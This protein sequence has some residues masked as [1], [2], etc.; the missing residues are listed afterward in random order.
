[1]TRRILCYNMLD[2]KCEGSVQTP[3][4]AR[5]FSLLENGNILFV[6]PK[7]QGHKQVVVTDSICNII[8]EYIDFA[9][10]DL[11]N[12]T[13]YSLLQK[14][15]RGLVYS[16]PLRNEVYVF[17]KKD[18]CLLEEFLFLIDGKK[19]DDDSSYSSNLRIT[20][21]ILGDGTVLGNY[22]KGRDVFFYQK[23]LNSNRSWVRDVLKGENNYSDLLLPLCT[24]GD[25]LILSYLQEEVYQK[26]D[27]T[28][29][30]DTVYEEYL[31]NGGFLI[32]VFRIN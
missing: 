4:F 3:F 28:L 20:P 17:S 31:E 22:V 24:S 26:M 30:L 15:E 21:I 27:K 18:G 29:P 25:S 9:E 16:K 23:S 7:D 2:Y 19:Y 8:S 32:G 11:D 6:L 5:S 14:T 1:M 10:D 13:R 12:H